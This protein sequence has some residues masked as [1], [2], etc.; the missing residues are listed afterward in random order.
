MTDKEIL[1]AVQNC[2]NGCVKKCPYDEYTLDYEKCMS[3]LM[4]DALSLL[5]RQNAEIDRL[6]RKTKEQDEIIANSNFAEFYIHKHSIESIE[7]YTSDI[8]KRA[9]KEFKER[10]IENKYYT[11]NPTGYGTYAVMVDTINKIAEKMIGEGNG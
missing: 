1:E 2:A 10:L 4:E 8:Y 6:Q 7:G 5:N 9:I 3:D 11:G